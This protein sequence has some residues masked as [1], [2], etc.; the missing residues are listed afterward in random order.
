L[1]SIGRPVLSHLNPP[2]T[3]H[4]PLWCDQSKAVEGGTEAIGSVGRCP[5]GPGRRRA[6]AIAGC[7]ASRLP[8]RRLDRSPPRP[9]S[10]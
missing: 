2:R 8:W 5:Q 7:R 4:R 1:E 3:A 9:P 6:R 10:K